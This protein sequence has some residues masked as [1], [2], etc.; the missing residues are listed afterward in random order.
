[1]HA[2][3]YSIGWKLSIGAGALYPAW[4]WKSCGLVSRWDDETNRVIGD[5]TDVYRVG[6]SGNEIYR[7]CDRCGIPR[8][9]PGTGCIG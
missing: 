1:M 3:T 9:V 5:R 2:T 6:R 8:F 7:V 4:V